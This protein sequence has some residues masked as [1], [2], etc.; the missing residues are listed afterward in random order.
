MLHVHVCTCL[1]TNID[2][3]CRRFTCSTTQIME[4]IM[5][6]SCIDFCNLFDKHNSDKWF[7]Q[8][9]VGC[10]MEFRRLPDCLQFYAADECPSVTTRHSWVSEIV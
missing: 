10:V 7:Q 2:D 8:V 1:S 9:Q 3:Q 4:M 5:I 6:V